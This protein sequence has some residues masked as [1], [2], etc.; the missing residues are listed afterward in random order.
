MRFDLGALQKD[1]IT[2]LYHLGVLSKEVDRKL[3]GLEYKYYT[4]SNSTT[5]QTQTRTESRG[6]NNKIGYEI[7][8]AADLDYATN[9]ITD[10]EQEIWGA[11][12]NA[13][14]QR[15]EQSIRYRLYH[16]ELTLDDTV[17]VVGEHETKIDALQ[18]EK[19]NKDTEINGKKL[20]LDKQ[21]PN[22]VN[23][24]EL[25]TIDIDEPENA[26][27]EEH[28]WFTQE[29]VSKNPDVQMAKGHAE[30]VSTGTQDATLSKSS[31]SGHTQKNPHNLSTDDLVVLKNSQKLFVTSDEERR[32]RSDKLP[33]DTKAELNK[34]I[35]NITIASIAGNS[36]TTG[37]SPVELGNVK[38]LH[39]YQHGSKVDVANG[40][41][42]IECVGQTNP[43]DFLLKDEFAKDAKKNPGKYYGA[44]DRAIVADNVTALKTAGPNQ[45]YGTTEEKDP[46]DPEG[47]RYK[48]AAYDLPRYVT[49]E[50][51]TKFTDVDKVTFAPIDRSITLKHL[52][53]S[54]VT[55]G[56]NSE[57]NKL[58][59]NV[60]DLVKNHYHKV[61]NNGTQGPYKPGSISIQDTSSIKYEYEVPTGGL[62]GRTYY[63]SYNNNTYSFTAT[64][65]M[66]AKTILTYL[67][68]E[69]SLSYTVPG[70]DS[71]VALTI[72]K[73]TDVN[74][75]EN[76]YW[77]PFAPQTDWNKIN[78]WNFGDTLTVNVTNGRATINVKDVSKIDTP[79]S[80]YF[81]NLADV[82]VTMDETNLGKMLVLG[83]V[84]DEYKLQFTDAPPL[85]KYMEIIDYVDSVDDK[86]VQ[87]AALADSATVAVSANTLQKKYI[88]NDSANS[89]T[90]LWTADKI[91]SNTTAQIKA[92]GVNTYYD[93][94]APTTIPGAKDGD[95]YI[96][97]EG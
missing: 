8:D 69:N 11:V 36:Q 78:E 46:D 50:D 55:Y 49:T 72:T 22:E 31:V 76:D 39:F 53:N 62:L 9:R 66:V 96:M 60:Y 30:T 38:A 33:D 19:V 26:T 51:A 35:E 87:Y 12:G 3:F 94:G 6:F 84:K 5:K 2:D 79:Y 40:I 34:K 18:K 67:P 95:L 97:I 44:V 1:E 29:R 41:A 81:G 17:R 59:T 75:I 7:A 54:R 21:D 85:N 45:Y 14:K 71:S 52:A 58:Q 48:I 68:S 86:R 42:T 13:G 57:E 47:K 61:Y 10:I 64:T 90:N 15:H 73:V 80:N 63:F 77:L 43:D 37:G 92:E 25:K 24:I 20:G 89:N 16:A 74:T 83:Q 82:N 88:V 91:S 23:K 65:A 28:Q 4:D 93:T 27:E 32:I 56:A 70:A